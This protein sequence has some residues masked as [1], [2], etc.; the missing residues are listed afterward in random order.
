MPKKNLY[1]ISADSLYGIADLKTGKI[2]V[3]AEYTTIDVLSDGRFLLTRYENQASSFYYAD[4]SGTVTPIQ[5]PVKGTYFSM[6]GDDCFFI[7]AYA[8]RPLTAAV[9]QPAEQYDI[10]TPVL[11]NENMKVIRD[12]IDGTCGAVSTPHFTNGL[13]PIQTGSTLWIDSRKGALG[14]GTYG[15]IDKGGEIRLPANASQESSWAKAE[16]EAAR[17]HDISLS[18][19]YPR[20][21]ITRVDFCR[22]AVKL[23]Q[24]VQPNAS[25]APAAAFS[26]CENG[27][28]CLAAALGIVTGYV[29]GTFRPYQSITRQQ[30]ALIPYRTPTANRC[31]PF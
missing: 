20:L 30:A 15:L 11:L 17:E 2:I 26:D 5:T 28:V 1:K 13:M 27:S 18:F 25:A 22:L 23:Y 4:A 19:Y 24:K 7:G 21:N 3:P 6:A 31:A 29:D 8:K 10:P 12:D 9:Q 14:N 16:L